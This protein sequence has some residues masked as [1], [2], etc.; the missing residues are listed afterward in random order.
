[1]GEE[2][3]NKIALKSAPNGCRW[4]GVEKEK[5]STDW[6]EEVQ[7]HVWVA[8]T[9]AQRKARILARAAQ[10]QPLAFLCVQ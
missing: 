10:G 9:D 5:H 8:P 1:M 2:S 7:Y 6:A 4:C 3:R